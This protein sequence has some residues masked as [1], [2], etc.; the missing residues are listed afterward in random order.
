V[1]AVVEYLAVA[2]LVVTPLAVESAA[3]VVVESS[4]GGS[5]GGGLG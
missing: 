1:A 3:G 5:A 2:D 4:A